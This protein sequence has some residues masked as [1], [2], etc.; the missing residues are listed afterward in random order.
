[1][2]NLYLRILPHPPP[3]VVMIVVLGFS[4]KLGFLLLI[5]TT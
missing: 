2:I 1:L 3:S 4:L 5:A